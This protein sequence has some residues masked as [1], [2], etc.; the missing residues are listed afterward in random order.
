MSDYL[1]YIPKECRQKNFR[2]SCVFASITNCLRFVRLNDIADRFWEQYRGDRNGE[3]PGGLA[4]KLNQ[5][6][7]NYKAVTRRSEDFLME[8]LETGRGVAISWGYK[9]MVNLV[10]KI[11]NNAYIL[12]NKNPSRYVIQSWSKFMRM[13]N[14]WA[15][16][17]LDGSPPN[18]IIKPTIRG[19]E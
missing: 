15:V 7:I 14:G 3:N 1:V 4:D 8:G 12:D 9:H 18:A 11:N 2:A 10:G 16:I 5:W 17:I 13:Y 6:E 19:F